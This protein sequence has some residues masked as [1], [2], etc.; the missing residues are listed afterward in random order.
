MSIKCVV[1]NR[2]YALRPGNVMGAA[3][4]GVAILL[5]SGCGGLFDSPPGNE[6]V[7]EEVALKRMEKLASVTPE[8]VIGKG[9]ET[10]ADKAKQG[11]ADITKIK[12][13]DS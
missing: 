7:H 4:M 12:R 3:F 10:A 11:A 5:L 13:N 1:I 6:N 9:A 2:H 8:S